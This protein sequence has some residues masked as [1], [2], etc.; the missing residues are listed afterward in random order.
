MHNEFE[1]CGKVS[2]RVFYIDL[3]KNSVLVISYKVFLFFLS[4]SV[5]F[6]FV[7]FLQILSKR[8]REHFF[9]SFLFFCEIF[10]A[11]FSFA[12]KEWKSGDKFNGGQKFVLRWDFFASLQCFSLFLRESL[13]RWD[14]FSFCAFLFASLYLSVFFE[15]ALFFFIFLL[16]FLLPFF[17]GLGVARAILLLICRHSSFDRFSR[18]NKE[19]RPGSGS[20]SS[21]FS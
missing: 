8:M 9:W 6:F 18:Q 14:F 4:L 19:W 15:I 13:F 12:K 20:A 1:L 2:R 11:S 16:F 7:C 10:S 21:C 3:W 17:A 5:F